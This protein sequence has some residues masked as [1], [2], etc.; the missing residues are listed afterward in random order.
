M[1]KP[2]ETPDKDHVHCGVD[3]RLVI[4]RSF[5]PKISAMLLEI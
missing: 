3:D 2:Y 1:K 4:I 5:Q